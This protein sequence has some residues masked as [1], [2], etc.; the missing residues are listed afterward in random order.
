[1]NNQKCKIRPEMLMV[2]VMS[3]YFILL[4]LKQVKA[5]VVAIISIIP[6]QKCV[7][8]MLLKTNV[9]VFN[10]TSR[11]NETRHIKWHETCQC[12]CRLDA[13]VCN[14]KQRWNDDK[15]RCECKELIDK[16][17]CDKRSIWNPSNCEC[18]CDK[19]SD[20]GEYLDYENCKCRKKL[21]DKLVEECTENI[22]EAKIAGMALSEHGNDSYTICVVLVVI[23]LPISIGIGAYFIYSCWYL[24]NDVT[25]IK[26]GTRTQTTI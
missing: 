12:K 22:D 25:H 23:A 14:N 8:L 9:K 20:V 2:I 3:L 7:F 1:M 16:G 19:S 6:G 18:K 11:T 5:V 13:S 4:V 15:C 26:F 21:V 10:L 17:E 24:K